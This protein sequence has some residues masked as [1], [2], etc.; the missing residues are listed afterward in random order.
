MRLAVPDQEGPVPPSLQ[1][2]LRLLPFHTAAVP[3]ALLLVAV[4]RQ[5]VW[6]GGFYVI[7]THRIRKNPRLL[8]ASVKGAGLS[9]F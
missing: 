6:A 1:Q 2:L 5:G 3:A 9:K 8:R 4:V 7:K